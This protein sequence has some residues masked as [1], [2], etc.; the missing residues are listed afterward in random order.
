MPPAKRAIVIDR[1]MIAFALILAVTAASTEAPNYTCDD[2]RS[3]QTWTFGILGSIVAIRG[4]A[5]DLG[6]VVTGR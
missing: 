4:R 5:N 6:L 2:A 1:L 3:T